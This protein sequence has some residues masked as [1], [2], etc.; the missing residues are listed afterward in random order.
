MKTR[1]F[2]TIESEKIWDLI[3]IVESVFDWSISF[4]LISVKLKMVRKKLRREYFKR[5]SVEVIN[6]I[7]YYFISHKIQFS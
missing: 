6:R 2:K 7:Y 4:S 1:Q 5:R 3:I